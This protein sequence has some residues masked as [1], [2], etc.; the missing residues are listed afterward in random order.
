[1]ESVVGRRVFVG[2]VVAGVPLLAV[3]RV[4]TLGQAGGAAPHAHPAPEAAVDA[5]AEHIVRQL[6][7]IHNRI[8]ARGPRGE[9]ARAMAAHLRTLVVHGRQIDLD[10]RARAGVRALIELRGRDEVLYHERD[11]RT[12]Q[13]EMARFGFDVDTRLLHRVPSSDYAT[14]SAALDR[15]LRDGVTPAWTRMADTLDRLA[16]ELDRRGPVLPVARVQ[17]SDWWAGFCESI[18]NDFKTTQM[19]AG[20]VC[21][22]AALPFMSFLGPSCAAL[23]GGAFSLLMIYIVYC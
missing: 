8:R 7:V 9:D 21:G 19:W 18:W 20:S 2:T 23:Q 11:S 17:D 15:L 4:R 3:T 10:G 6:G 5:V 14:R 12:V 22:T 16:P 1:M 13:A